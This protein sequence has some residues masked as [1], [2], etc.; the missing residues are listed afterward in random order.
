MNYRDLRGRPLAKG[1]NKKGQVYDRNLNFEKGY[2]ELMS[3][4]A[5]L[6]K[7]V[8]RI[9]QAITLEGAQEYASKRKNWEAFEE[10]ITGPDGKPDGIP[11][12]IVT[13]AKGNV[14]II[15]GMTLAKSK[16]PIRK[17]YRTMYKTP[18]ERK[19]NPMGKFKNELY[20][21]SSEMDLDGYKYT[22]PTELIGPGFEN[23]RQEIKTRDFFKKYVFKPIYEKT[24]EYLKS[25][26]QPMQMAQVANK[27]LSRIYKMYIEEPVITNLIGQNPEKKLITKTKKSDVF[28]NECIKAMKDILELDEATQNDM[29]HDIETMIHDIVDEILGQPFGTSYRNFYGVSPQQA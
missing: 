27:G 12:V 15:N 8:K 2:A 7:D 14:K 9:N 24:K 26:L 20:D 16:Y 25:I 6:Q 28:K 23:I 3:I 19:A 21:I 29:K 22:N 18:E 17:A 13:D 10:D 1:T 5:E 4:V 11:E